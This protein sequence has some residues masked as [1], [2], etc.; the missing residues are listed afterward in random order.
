MTA[1]LTKEK[2]IRRLAEATDRPVPFCGD[3]VDR[4]ILEMMD[5]FQSGQDVLITGFGKFL[6]TDKHSR[7]G[8]NPQPRTTI[9]LAPRRVVTIKPSSKFRDYLNGE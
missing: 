3:V 5:C 1:T 8:R 4:L 2:L 7:K 6:V 9:Q